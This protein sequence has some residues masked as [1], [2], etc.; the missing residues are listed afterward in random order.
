MAQCR[1]TKEHYHKN[2][3]HMFKFMNEC[4]KNGIETDDGTYN[5]NCC[6]PADLSCHWKVLGMGG[7]CKVSEMFCHLCGCTSQNCAKFK[8]GSQRCSTCIDDNV[9]KCYHH[10]MDD[11]EEI[12][13]KIKRVL[14]LEGKYSYLKDLEVSATNP[15]CQFQCDPTAVNKCNIPSHIEYEP[16]SCQEALTFSQSVIVK[17]RKQHISYARLSASGHLAKLRNS[18]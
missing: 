5:I 3:D 14:E 6:F 4:K 1:E 9:A 18:L 8:T 11:E 12:V 13:R 15:F 16:K 10:K 2:I 17:L 7:A